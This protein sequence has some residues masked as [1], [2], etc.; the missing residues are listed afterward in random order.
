MYRRGGVMTAADQNTTTSIGTAE[1]MRAELPQGPI[2]YREVGSGPP[3]VFV[4]GLLVDRRLWDGVADRL[5]GRARCIAPDWPMGSHRLPMRP[6][7]D[8]SPPGMAA[9]IAGFIDSLSLDDVTLVGNDTGGA[10]CQILVT[11]HPER[12]GR[13]V[14][15]NCD[16]YEHFPPGPFK[17]MPSIAK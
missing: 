12:I 5:G 8:L 16:S 9:T 7:A 11:S 14:L 15:T 4:H 2:A 3:V 17:L 6:D 10:I 1:Q 13:L